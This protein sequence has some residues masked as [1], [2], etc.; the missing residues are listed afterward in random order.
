MQ[1]LTDAKER[2]SS[3]DFG[4][5]PH[6]QAEIRDRLSLQNPPR[7][8]WCHYVK[9]WVF[10]DFSNFDPQI[11]RHIHKWNHTFYPFHP[12]SPYTSGNAFVQTWGDANV[13]T[14]PNGIASSSKWASWSRSPTPN[15]LSEF[16][17]EMYALH[18]MFTCYKHV[19]FTGQRIWISHS[20]FLSSKKNQATHGMEVLHQPNDR[21]LTAGNH[22]NAT[23]PYIHGFTDSIFSTASPFMASLFILCKWLSWVAHDIQWYSPN[24]NLWNIMMQWLIPRVLPAICS[25]MASRS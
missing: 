1:V 11:L 24:L 7:D 4:I 16:F 18:V 10:V 21:P 20:P 19:C 25:T 2:S 8:A 23:S 17:D 9:S 6:L 13:W 15:N 22:Q 12:F 5:L 14:K 3:M